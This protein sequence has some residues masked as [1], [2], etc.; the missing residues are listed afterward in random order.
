MIWYNWI[1]DS[2][3]KKFLQS[4]KDTFKV[5]ILN[6]LATNILL[7]IISITMIIIDLDDPSKFIQRLI[8][9]LFLT[10]MCTVLGETYTNDN[11]KRYIIYIIGLLISIVISKC[12]LNTELVRYLIGIIFLLGGTIL[13]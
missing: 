3:I 11:K 2:M 12:I 13:F 10:A 6:H 5:Y 7:I 4:L 1:G 8:V 9:T